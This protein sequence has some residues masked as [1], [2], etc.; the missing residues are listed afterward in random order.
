MK[1]EYDFSNATR[2]K[3]FRKDAALDTP[4]A[5]TARPPDVDVGATTCGIFTAGEG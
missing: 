4:V 5:L 1:D 3:F 2:G